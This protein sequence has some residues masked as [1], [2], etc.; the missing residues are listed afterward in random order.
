MPRGTLFCS[1]TV[2]HVAVDFAVQAG[3]DEVILVGT[4]FSYPM[5]K[6]H[7]RGAHGEQEIGGGY[8]Y[9]VKN[10]HGESI[11]SDPN[12]IM[13]LRDL[14]LYVSKHAGVKFYTLGLEGARIEG[15]RILVEGGEA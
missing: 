7:A 2:V 8:H 3:A 5:G 1:G 11:V 15:T 10:G 12:L 9:T 6:T 4:D 14:E 13:Y